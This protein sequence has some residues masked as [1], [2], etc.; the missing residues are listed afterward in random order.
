MA[1]VCL[2]CELSE[3]RAAQ[4]IQGTDGRID[5]CVICQRVGGDREPLRVIKKETETRVVK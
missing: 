4:I 3:G 2:G 1:D 5:A